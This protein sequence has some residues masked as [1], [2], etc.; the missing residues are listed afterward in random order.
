MLSAFIRSST[1]KT[2]I[3][4]ST[5]TSFRYFDQTRNLFTKDFLGVSIFLQK[6]EIALKE[7]SEKNVDISTLRKDVCRSFGV[8]LNVE[9][10]DEKG[11]V[12][13]EETPGKVLISEDVRKMIYTSKS[14]KVTNCSLINL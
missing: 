3:I 9:Q 1:V 8:V 12:K 5:K 6:K 2:S 4:C 11:V 10:N 13:S 14:F 7:L